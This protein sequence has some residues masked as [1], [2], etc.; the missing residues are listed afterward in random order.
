MSLLSHPT[1]TRARAKCFRFTILPIRSVGEVKNLLL[2]LHSLCSQS[3]LLH[4]Q[5]CLAR[6][7]KWRETET[8]ISEWLSERAKRSDAKA[9][10]KT[11]NRIGEWD[12]SRVSSSSWH[13]SVILAKSEGKTFIFL[14]FFFFRLSCPSAVDISSQAEEGGRRSKRKLFVYS[15]KIERKN[16][17]WEEAFHLSA[18]YISLHLPYEALN[19][20]IAKHRLSFLDSHPSFIRVDDHDKPLRNRNQASGGKSR[21]SRPKMRKIKISRGSFPRPRAP[22]RFTQDSPPQ[23]KRKTYLFL[24]L[25]PQA[26]LIIW[27]DGQCQYRR[28]ESD[29]NSF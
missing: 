24:I 19:Y 28:D 10:K 3:L 2:P 27:R 25:Y 22:K 7:T 4:L 1:C 12:R 8:I 9:N 14:L 13:L 20:E 29:F 18:R 15:V 6:T 26:V 21:A 11:R 5:P 17:K 23:W 16:V